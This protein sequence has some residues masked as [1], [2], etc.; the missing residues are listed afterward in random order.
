MI[1]HPARLEL[2]SSEPESDI[3][4]IELRVLKTLLKLKRCFR[5]AQ[6]YKILFNE[7]FY[8]RNIFF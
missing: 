5:P 4:S 1:V 6:S 7:R 2:A 8:F 3:L